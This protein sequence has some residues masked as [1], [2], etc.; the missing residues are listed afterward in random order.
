LCKCGNQAWSHGKCYRCWHEMKQKP[1]HGGMCRHCQVVRSSRPRGLCW[2]CYRSRR[3]RNQYPSTSKFAHRGLA[4]NGFEAEQLPAPT[5]AEPGT[6]EK[7]EVLASRLAGGQHLW[8]DDDA[9][10]PAP[11]VKR[12]FCKCWVPQSLRWWFR[13]IGNEVEERW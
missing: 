1:R 3:I 11:T 2:A 9:E 13:N 7:I 5:S 10:L 6:P 12:G 8:N 4:N